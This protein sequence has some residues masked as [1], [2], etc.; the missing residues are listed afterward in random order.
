MLTSLEAATRIG[1]SDDDSQLIVLTWR[2]VDSDTEGHESRSVRVRIGDVS[3]PVASALSM[4]PASVCVLG[5]QCQLLLDSVF[6]RAM[7]RMRR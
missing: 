2:D 4:V 5:A 3:S 7:V 1:D 6:V